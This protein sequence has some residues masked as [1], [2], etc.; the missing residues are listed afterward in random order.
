VK[1]YFNPVLTRHY[2]VVFNHDDGSSRIIRNVGTL[3]SNYMALCF[4]R[5]RVLTSV[6]FVLTLCSLVGRY[7]RFEEIFCPNFMAD[8]S[9]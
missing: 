9:R 6:L 1:S 8:L 7:K 2:L 5:Q 3:S 4:I